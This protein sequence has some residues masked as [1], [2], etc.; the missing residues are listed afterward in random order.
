M[1][2][3]HRNFGP[4]EAGDHSRLYQGLDRRLRRLD[5]DKAASQ[6][7]LSLKGIEKESLRVAP[8]G[9]IAQSPHPAG[10][11][12]P[13]THPFI[14]TDYSEALLELITPPMVEVGEVLDFLRDAHSFVYGHLG[15]E[16]L[17]ATSMPCILHGPG[18]I[19]IAQY[20]SSNTGL[21]K[22]I[23][24]RGL[25]HRYGRLMQVIAGVHFNFSLAM[26][27]WPIYQEIEADTTSPPRAFRDT[28]YFALIRNLLRYGWLIPYLFGTSPAVCKT[29]LDDKPTSLSEFDEGTYFLP[30]ATS[31]RMGDIGYQNSRE[32][33]AGVRVGYDSLDT[34]IAS[35]RAAIETPCPAYERIG[36]VVNGQYEQ[37][38]ANILQ[39]ENEYYSSVRPKPVPVGNEK[40]T[41][42]LERRGVQYVE[43]RSLDVNAFHPLGIAPGQLKFLE[44]FLTF[45]L[46]VDSPPISRQEHEEI[47]DNQ[48]GVA[49][50]GRDSTWR[51]RR[52]GREIGLKD[53]A[54]EILEAMQGVCELL[55][56]GG[57]A[58]QPYSQSLQAQQALV[59][60]PDLTPSARMLAE[61]REQDE[62]FYAFARRKSKEHQRYFQGVKLDPEREL[63]FSAAAVRSR[64]QQQ[65]IEARDDLSLDE[66]LRRYFAQA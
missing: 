56:D 34:Y 35:L 65:E 44:A 12:S 33:G 59:L 46:L 10:L 57:D 39:I 58:S 4:G 47:N 5:E 51:L 25:G 6:L 60:E 28:S 11:G 16:F 18:S 19:P 27:F 21:M 20:G 63:R 62:S 55:D 49:H 17:W 38:N 53:W 7:R 1:L 29:F 41:L 2:I 32:R 42:A 40:P 43:L 3:H 9:G 45:C 24:R 64:Q 8:Q 30:Y 66:Y 22:T 23:Y 26:D 52:Q 61:M 37:L 36:V 15:E 13:L 54:G 50:R 14:T 48:T 31:L